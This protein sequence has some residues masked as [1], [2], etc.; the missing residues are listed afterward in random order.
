M[1]SYHIHLL[2]AQVVI[3]CRSLAGQDVYKRQICGRPVALYLDDGLTLEIL[4]CCT[5]GTDNACSC[6]LY[7][8]LTAYQ[9]IQ[10]KQ[11]SMIAGTDGK[12]VDGMGMKHINALIA[13]LREIGRAHV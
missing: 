2:L 11:G 9:K 4:R 13:K 7:T 12:T 1:Q 6:L 8:S 10:A 5:D 3:S